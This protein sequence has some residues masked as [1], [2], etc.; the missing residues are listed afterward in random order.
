MAR[1]VNL[2]GCIRVVMTGGCEDIA[3]INCSGFSGNA[4]MNGR[5][6]INDGRFIPNL[7]NTLTSSNASALSPYDMSGDLGDK[8]KVDTS[9]GSVYVTLDTE[10]LDG[11]TVNFKIVDATNTLVLS[12]A[13]NTETIDGNALPY[14][15][16]PTVYDNYVISSDG[17]NFY[18]L[19]KYP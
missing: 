6:Y 19:G 3:L 10:A 8:Y 18:I 13:T 1:N 4:S 15:I 7:W 5:T 2:F 17:T 16:T 14:T 12:T 9:G 11:V